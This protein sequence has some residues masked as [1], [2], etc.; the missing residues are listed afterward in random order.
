MRTALACVHAH[1]DDESLFTAGATARY[2][3]DGREVLLVTC[4]YGQLGFD[5]RGRPGVFEDHDAAQ[6]RATRAAELAQA[7]DLVGATRC[8]T[9]GYLDSGAPDWPSTSDPRAFAN[10]DPEKVARTLAALFD[11][12]D[13]AVVLTYDEN[14]FYGHPD[15]VM[16]NRAARIA[17]ELSGSV[18][19]L[20]YPVA[21]QRV[22]DEFIP[23]ARARG[24]ALPVFVT[25]AVGVPDSDVDC[26][27]DASSVAARKQ[28]AI[29]AHAS[30]IDNADLVTMD[31]DLFTLLFGT[32][33]YRRAWSRSPAHGDETDL[34]GGLT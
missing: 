16:A 4:T 27:I 9:L 12:V 28:A 2:A 15:H 26:V 21:P 19:R 7:S 24:V 14:G 30:Q 20:Y 34:F 25:S 22:L 17:V 1:P 5:A 29:A 6:T 31:A 18:E 32:E 10:A 13:A 8:A 3:D 11:E 23:A 33:Y